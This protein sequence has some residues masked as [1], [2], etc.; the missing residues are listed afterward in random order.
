MQACQSLGA[1][2]SSQP[3]FGIGVEHLYSLHLAAGV[4]AM[5]AAREQYVEIQL[6]CW[7]CTIVQS[8]DPCR[9]SVSFGAAQLRLR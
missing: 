4:E 1:S 9:S 7:R 3:L 8:V 5:V 2:G 6:L